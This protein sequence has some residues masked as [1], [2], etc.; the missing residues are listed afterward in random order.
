MKNVEMDMQRMVEHFNAMDVPYQLEMITDGG[1][2]EKYVVAKC[3]WMDANYFQ[4]F[5]ITEEIQSFAVYVKMEPNGRYRFFDSTE[6]LIS[7]GG[8]LNNTLGASDY[9]SSFYGKTLRFRK[10]YV[11]GKDNVNG[12]TG[13]VG[14]TL[15]TES[16]HR[17][18]KEWLKEN[19][20]QKRRATYKDLINGLRMSLNPMI[21]TIVGGGFSLGGFIFVIVGLVIMATGPEGL[22]ITTT[23]NGVAQT[24][25]ASQEETRI[26]GACFAGFGGLFLVQG[27]AMLIIHLPVLLAA[28]KNS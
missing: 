21:A 20:Y 23:V 7:S 18:L 17:P 26:F 19:G 12:R 15:N 16:V 9:R 6:A 25:I 11:L 5:A 14:F 1:S 24:H 22:E 27:I 10:T 2:G 4:N 13:L 8:Y 28:R 3:K